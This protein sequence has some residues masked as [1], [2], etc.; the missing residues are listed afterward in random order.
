M[1]KIHVTGDGHTPPVAGSF[2]Y[3]PYTNADKKKVVERAVDILKRNVRGSKSCNSC[4]QRLTGG[5]TFDAILDDP[6]TF[7]HYD[8]GNIQGRF[9][10]TRTGTKNVTITEFSIR[11]GRWTVAATLVH[12]FAHVNGASGSTHDAEATL[13]KCGFG[14]LYDPTIIGLVPSQ[15]ENDTR[16]A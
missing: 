5:R 6:D 12:E 11:M 1:A 14:G 8:P 7:I 16:I 13:P 2:Q 10:A 15:E 4:F 9:G 3:L